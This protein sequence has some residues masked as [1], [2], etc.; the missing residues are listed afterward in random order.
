MAQN[1]LGN[2]KLIIWLK[3]LGTVGFL[4]FLTKGILWIV[5]IGLVALGVVDGNA[6]QKIKSI[7]TFW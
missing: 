2:N 3:R 4:F 7:F 1:I 6:M 5:V